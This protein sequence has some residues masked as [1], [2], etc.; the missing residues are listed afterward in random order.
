MTIAA[1]I[2]ERIND[3]LIIPGTTGGPTF[4]TQ[5]NQGRSG[6]EQRNAN[7]TYSLSEYELGERPLLQPEV[8]ALN[9]LVRVFQGKL[10]GF[11]FKDWTDYRVTPQQGQL[12]LVPGTT[13]QYSLWKQYTTPG[14]NSTLRLIKKPVANTVKLFDG[15]AQQTAFTVNSDGTVTVNWTVQSGLSWSGQFDVPVRLDVD[16]LKI[17]F[18]AG[19]PDQQASFY[20][21]SLPL[22]EIRV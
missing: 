4:S 14:G 10:V 2:D 15:G 12:Q 3:G 9:A 19:N 18:K 17:G 7:W 22:V 21:H 1:F 13:N 6:Y 5:V 11:R 16:K 20:L 8:D